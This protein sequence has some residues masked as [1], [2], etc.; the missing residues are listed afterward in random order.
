MDEK[1]QKVV[2]IDMVEE[3]KEKDV[4]KLMFGDNPKDYIGDGLQKIVPKPVNREEKIRQML[5][6]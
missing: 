5:K 3:K 4:V 2:V 1:K 6:I